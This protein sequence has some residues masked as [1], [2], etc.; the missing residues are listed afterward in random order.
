AQAKTAALVR[1]I[2]KPVAVAQAKAVTLTKQRFA[3]RSFAIA[4]AKTLALLK[5]VGKLFNILQ[6]KTVAL[7]ATATH[8]SYPILG[9]ASAEAVG[10]PRTP[11]FVPIGERPPTGGR[12]PQFIFPFEV[13]RP[14]PQARIFGIAGIPTAQAVGWPYASFAWFGQVTGIGSAERL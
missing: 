8:V 12:A 7:T 2:T 3:I 11:Q 9:I 6:G 10:F 4:Q 5:T 13:P 14:K 1:A